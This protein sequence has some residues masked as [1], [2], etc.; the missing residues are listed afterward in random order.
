V[1]LALGPFG[2]RRLTAYK[3]W[4]KNGIAWLW[5]ALAGDP[6]DALPEKITLTQIVGLRYS[7]I[8]I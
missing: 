3:S 5:K 8:S 1:E 4:M 2:R 6:R 7:R